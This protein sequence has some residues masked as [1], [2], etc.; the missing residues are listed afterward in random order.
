MRLAHCD[1]AQLT[2]KSHLIDYN[3]QLFLELDNLAAM[4]K[5]ASLHVKLIDE[6]KPTLLSIGA[7]QNAKLFRNAP[8]NLALVDD[9]DSYKAWDLFIR[10]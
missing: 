10:R 4:F 6:I 5:P 9:N 2:L 7:E 3:K 1:G 8:S